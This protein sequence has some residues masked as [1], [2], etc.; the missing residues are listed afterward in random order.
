MAVL[1]AKKIYGTLANIDK[2]RRGLG[3][4]D[5]NIWRLPKMV[6]L[7]R[8]TM[9]VE[10]D[11]L[12]ERLIADKVED[13]EPGIWDDIALA[14]MNL[15]ALVLAAP[16]GGVS[17]A[18]AATVNAVV[19][20]EHLQEYILEDA[21]ANSAI[22]AAQA[23]AQDEPSLFWLAVDLIGVVLDFGVCGGEP[24]RVGL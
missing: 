6:E 8:A 5:V 18:V 22:D 14:V 11:P 24:A 4:G 23:L 19:A 3:N 15:V 21:L 12:K 16:T 10:G 17:L 13:E 7:T 20:Y 2:S 9:G 1:L